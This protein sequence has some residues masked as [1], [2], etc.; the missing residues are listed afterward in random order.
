MLSP[1]LV[2]YSV[3]IIFIAF[4]SLREEVNMSQRVAKLFT[5]VEMPLVGL[6]TWK[7]KPGQVE[8]AVKVAIDAGYRSID[9]AY[10]YGNEKEIGEALK[11]KIGTVCS[12]EELFITSKLWNT[13]HRPED[14]RPAI[15]Q[16]LKD[17]QL[18]YLDL[19]LIHWPLS[20]QP[21]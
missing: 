6:G 4:L 1:S 8:T 3:S 10:I 18:D 16:S 2:F 14:V 12:R 20:F 13:M 15:I 5:G 19:Y 9:G 7:S 17:L 21:G 11:E